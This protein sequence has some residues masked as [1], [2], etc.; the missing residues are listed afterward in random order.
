MEGDAAL[1]WFQ[2]NQS[3][4]PTGTISK[5]L[6]F[7]NTDLRHQI[8]TDKVNLAAFNDGDQ[9]TSILD[10]DGTLTGY[11][12][13]DST[14]QQVAV[15]FPDSLNNLE[16]NGASNSVDECLAE[17]A[18]DAKFEGRPTSLILPANMGTLEFGTLYPVRDLELT[19]PT[20][21]TQ[22]I[23]C[24]PRTI[25]TTTRIRRSTCTA[26]TGRG[27]GNRRWPAASATR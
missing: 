6:I 17:G 10:E 14:G 11:Q 9:N 12:V 15:L 19:P 13:V 5:Q 1:G 18:Q 24:S 3:S 21:S 16:F 8:Y 7:E 20:D 25:W 23:T 26:A 27:C 2:S 22:F 4:Y